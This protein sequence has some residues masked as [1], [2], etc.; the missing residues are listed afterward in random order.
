MS[1]NQLDIGPILWER[2]R[3]LIRDEAVFLPE[4][5]EAVRQSGN[6]LLKWLEEFQSK[7]SHFANGILAEDFCDDGRGFAGDDS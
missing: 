2:R 1:F 5:S 7:E 4:S 6:T 3:I